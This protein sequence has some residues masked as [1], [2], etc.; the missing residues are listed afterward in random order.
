MTI[1]LTIPKDWS[2]VSAEQLRCIVEL[3][4]A[5]LSREAFLLVLLC[6]L[7]G[8]AMVAGTSEKDGKKTVHTLFK[9][10]DGNTFKLEDWAVADFCGRLAYT[11]DTVPRDI[12]CPFSWDRHLID[13]TFASWFH[14]D[15]LMLRYYATQN[16]EF[17]K[18][19]MEDLGDP[20]DNLTRL[21]VELMRIWWEDF[22]DWLIEQYPLVFKK[23]G[24]GLEGVISPLETRKNIMLMLN[25]GRP[26][27]NERIEDS[28]LHDVLSA[29]QY[30]IEEAEHVKQALKQ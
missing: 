20:H 24:K 7:S 4:D 21:D 10:K 8:I 26:Q 1:D 17:M 29:L 30:K 3:Y 14:A 6:K 18:A 16:E 19:A 27:D 11:L 28:N 22:Q 25:E 15:A 23:T 13:A 12:A 9:D 2:E 5:E